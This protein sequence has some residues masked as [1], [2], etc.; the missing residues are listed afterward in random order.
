[1]IRTIS[2]LV[3]LAGTG[4]R[5]RRYLVLVI[6]YGLAQGLALVSLVAFIDALVRSDWGQARVRAVVLLALAVVSAVLCYLQAR[7]GYAISL[8]IMRALQHRI[9]DHAAR[10]PLGWFG[11]SRPG[12][13]VQ[14]ATAGAETVGSTTA[15]LVEPMLSAVIAP[16]VVVVGLVFWDWRVALAGAVFVPLVGVI[17]RLVPRLNARADALLDEAASEVNG[18]V[19]DFALDQPLLR[20]T[21]R[22]VG[23]YPPLDEALDDYARAHR[24]NLW[25]TLPGLLVNSVAVQAWLVLLLAVT[26]AQALGGALSVPAAIG[27]LVV[28]ARFVDPLAQLSEYATALRASADALG[29]SQ[30]FLATPVLPEPVVPAAPDA[31]AGMSVVLDDVAFG[32][33]DDGPRV[34]SGVDLVARPGTMTALVGPSGAGKTTILRLIA[35]FWDVTGGS[36]R[37][38]GVDVRDL[39]SET[40]ID[41]VSIVFQD[42]YLFEGSIRDNVRQGRPGADDEEIRRAMAAARVLEIGERLPDGLDTQVG[43]G[44]AR[45]SGGERQRVSIAR[46]LLKDAPIVLLDEATASVDAENEVALVEAFRALVRDRTVIVIAHR[47]ETIAGADQICFLEAGRVVE[48]GRHDELLA[49]EGRYAAFWRAKTRASSWRLGAP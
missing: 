24:N 45:L 28:S 31:S 14:L 35:R 41:Q 23:S 11:R 36:V 48:R 32:Y 29:R 19:I 49:A 12:E 15:H 27:L 26:L 3:R 5:P 47:L 4:A 8:A 46:A 21:G 42:V 25:R 10:L 1:M 30:S 34:L 18:A 16:A 20:S 43:E 13:L 9:G 2:A 7:A 44:G 38:G 17:G 39:G 6:A 22:M 40:V 33:A 37:I